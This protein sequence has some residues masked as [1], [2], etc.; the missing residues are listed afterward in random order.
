MSSRKRLQ[1]KQIEGRYSR[2]SRADESDEGGEEPPGETLRADQAVLEG[3]R[4]V[5]GSRR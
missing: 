5:R 4:I 2:N 1:E 3:R